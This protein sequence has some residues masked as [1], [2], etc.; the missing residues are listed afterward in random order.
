MISDSHLMKL[1]FAVAVLGVVVLFFIVQLTEPLAV[2]IVEI[3]EAMSGQS[4]ITNGTI[5][6]FSTKDGNVFLTLSDEKEIKVVMF[7]KDAERNNIYQ[8][9][10]G[11]QIRVNG[12]VSVYRDELEIVAEQIENI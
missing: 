2:R 11:D 8:L 4:V 9:K 3:N 5:S 12:K 7:K 6:S 10:D 1:S